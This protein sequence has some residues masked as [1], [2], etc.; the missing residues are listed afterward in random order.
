MYC[1]SCQSQN[2]KNAQFCKNCGTKLFYAQEQN[3]DSNVSSV[4][5]IV[6]IGIV[7]FVGIISAAI[8]SLVDE[9]YAVPTKYVMICLNIIANVSHILPAL[10]IRNKTL[11]I[12]G[13]VLVSIIVIYW[14]YRQIEWALM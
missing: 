5:L 4:I 8:Q 1:P 2:E 12:I 14:V 6:W 3:P 13:I 7:F 11:K 9:W 10:A